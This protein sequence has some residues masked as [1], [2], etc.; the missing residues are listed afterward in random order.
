[1]I[2]CAI[3]AFFLYFVFIFY[4]SRHIWSKDEIDRHNCKAKIN[5]EYRILRYR[6]STENDFVKLLYNYD[7]VIE[8]ETDTVIIVE[9]IFDVVA[10]TR[11]LELYDNPH[12]AVVATFGKK[13]SQIQIYKLQCKGVKTVVLGYDSDATEAI[14]KAASTLNEYFNVFIAKIDAENGKDWDEMSF[15]EIYDTLSQNLL[16]PIEFKLNTL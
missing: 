10:L 2:C 11:K 6:N 5:G 12:V 8:D 9:G 1:M 7:A 13:I 14:N 3:I 4:I 16:S 15:W